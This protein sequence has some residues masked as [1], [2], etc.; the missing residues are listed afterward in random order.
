MRSILCILLLPIIVLAQDQPTPSFDFAEPSPFEWAMTTCDFDTSAKAVILLDKAKIYFENDHAVLHRHRRIK[1]LDR[2]A[3]GEADIKIPFIHHNDREQITNLKAITLKQRADGSIEEIKLERKDK[4]EEKRSEYYSNVRFAFPAVEEGVILEYRYNLR[5]KNYYYLEPWYFQNEL[6]TVHSEIK[7]L[8]PDYLYY[9]IIKMGN[10]LGERYQDSKES[11]WVLEELP[12]YKNEQFV[13]QPQDY[14]EQIR[15]QLAAY[16]ANGVWNKDVLGSWE[17]IAKE[18]LEEYDG[19]FKKSKRI[20]DIAETL[21][22]NHTNE[23]DLAKAAYEYVKQHYQWNNYYGKYLSVK[24]RDFLELKSGNLAELNI[25]LITLLRKLGISANPVLISTRGHGKFIRAFPLLSQFNAVIVKAN[26]GDRV[27]YMDVA[28]SKQYGLSWDLLPVY[29][30]NYY[31]FEL[32]KEAP[33]FVK[34]VPSNKSRVNTSIKLNL[35]D[36]AGTIESMHEGYEAAELR[37]RLI[38]NG[39]GPLYGRTW[40]LVEASVGISSESCEGQESVEEPIRC[41]YKLAFPEELEAERLYLSLVDFCSYGENPFKHLEERTLPVELPYPT[42]ENI[43]FKL[44][45]PEDWEVEELPEDGSIAL[46]GNAGKFFYRVK[47]LE[48]EVTISAVLRIHSTI[49]YP[50]AYDALRRFFDLIAEKMGQT[51]VIKKKT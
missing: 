26:I 28:G 31:G 9:N 2:T 18:M 45:L 35:A 3:F 33:K 30:L 48:Q 25:M 46:E 8:C 6:P 14:T 23:A 37:T 15:F 38:D 19:F 16:M 40:E 42:A 43:I 47:Q 51:V 20:N 5:T 10:R 36:R 11:K 4:F 21:K 29:D 22:R 1:I 24:F 34:I 7:L 41:K 12:G 17:I 32:D 13:Y 50:E 27:Y 49:Y 39:V 44:T